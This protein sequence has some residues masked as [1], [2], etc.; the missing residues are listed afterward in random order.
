MRGVELI[1][2]LAFPICAIL[3]QDNSQLANSPSKFEAASV[4]PTPPNTPGGG[5]LRF[6]PGGRLIISNILLNSIIAKAYGVLLY[7][8]TGAPSWVDS[9]RYEISAVAPGAKD[10]QMPGLL[11]ALLADRFHLVA[12]R[13]TRE[14]GVYELKLARKD[15]KL[16]PRLAL[17]NDGDCTPSEPGKP[18]ALSEYPWQLRCGRSS[19]GSGIV[20]AHAVAINE[21]VRVLSAVLGRKVI[22]QTGLTGKLDLHIRWHDDDDPDS[23]PEGPSIFTAFQ[24]QL[25]L[26]LEST[27][28]SVEVIV[29]DHVEKPSE[30]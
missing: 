28:G 18:G 25:G 3:A 10:S 14:I 27:K 13:E 4:K 9:Q 17:V 5:A 20:G 12:R 11:Q 2:T 24:E 16:G 23:E 30:N 21:F 8:I 1:V 29:I 19:W 15:G 7:Q 6:A 26:K 22:N